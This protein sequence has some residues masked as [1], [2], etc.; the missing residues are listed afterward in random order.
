M[1][2]EI[3]DSETADIAL[4]SALTGHL[5]LSTLHTNDSTSAISRLMDMGI[6]EFLISSTLLGVLAQR[7]TRKL[8]GYCKT[9]TRLSHVTLDELRLPSD[10][11]YYKANGCKECDYT[12]YKGR[13]AVG[14]L[15]I[16]DDNV[17]MMMKEG[18]NDH[19]I[20]VE[21]KK[22]GMKT[23][24]DRLKEMLIDGETSYEEAIRIGVMED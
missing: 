13:K 18:F 9:P 3:R 17:R 21:L 1:V 24:A 4:R 20:R 23:I 15:F 14:E 11:I 12:G 6:E 22:R 2:G 19:Q 16:M 5:M 8:C 10:T 7:L